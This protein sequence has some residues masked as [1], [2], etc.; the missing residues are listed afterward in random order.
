MAIFK[1]YVNPPER[2]GQNY[3]HFWILKIQ[4]AKMA[5]HGHRLFANFITWQ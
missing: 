3:Y 5:T 2:K 1:K 4:N